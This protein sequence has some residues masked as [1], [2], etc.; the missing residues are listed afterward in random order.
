[1]FVIPIST[2]RKS[3]FS[4][5]QA[6]T[7]SHEPI[8]LTSKKGNVVLISE[9]DFRSTQETL[10]LYSIPRLLE[11]VKKGRKTPKNKLKHREDLQ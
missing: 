3:L 7:E 9:E 6:V 4:L 1:M 8:I 5:A 2:A 10:Y 11:D